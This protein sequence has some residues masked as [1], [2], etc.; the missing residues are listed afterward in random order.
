MTTTLAETDV[1]FKNLNEIPFT[2]SVVATTRILSFASVSAGMYEVVLT[3][4][5]G[6][7]YWI[8]NILYRSGPNLTVINPIANSVSVTTGG[9]NNIT[10]TNLLTSSTY[11]ITVRYMGYTT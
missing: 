9:T 11:Y 8:G 10:F 1:G 7:R 4:D 5:V 2:T 6:G 3:A